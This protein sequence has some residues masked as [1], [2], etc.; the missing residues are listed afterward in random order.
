[1]IAD[2]HSTTIEIYY[3]IMGIMSIFALLLKWQGFP[4]NGTK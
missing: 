2:R 3:K 1:M 4:I